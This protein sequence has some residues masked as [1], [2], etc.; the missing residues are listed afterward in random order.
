MG[1]G[2]PDSNVYNNEKLGEETQN[3]KNY[4]GLTKKTMVNLTKWCIKN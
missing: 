3:A 4:R 2:V 1:K